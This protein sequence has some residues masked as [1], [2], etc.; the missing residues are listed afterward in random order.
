MSY[1]NRIYLKGNLTKDPEYKT[2]SDK[3]LVNFRIA[4]NE[5]VGQGKEET[6]YFDVD[7]WES[8]AK[9]AQNVSLQKGDRVHVEGR[10][11]QREWLDKNE[12]KRINYSILPNSFSKVFKPQKQD[13]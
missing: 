11:K 13:F 4:V 3:E 9:Y 1:N 2:I 8:H 7:G 6:V 10:I 5:S 12:Q